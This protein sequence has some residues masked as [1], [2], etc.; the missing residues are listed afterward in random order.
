[1]E[2]FENIDIKKILE[3]AFSKKIL[4]I[5]AL[6]LILSN[7]IGYVYTYNY[8]IPEYKSSVTVLLVAD[9]N[10]ETQE[11]TQTDLNLNSGLISTYS[12]IVKSNNIVSK[13]IKNLNLN[14]S[15]KNLQNSI[16]AIQVNKTQFLEISVKN[17]NPTLAKEIANELAEVFTAEIK[18]IYNLQNINIVD[19]AEIQSKPCNINHTKDMIIF[20]AGGVCISVVLIMAIYFFDDTIKNEQDIELNVKL[21]NIG[22]LPIDK[23]NEALIIESNPKSHI[24]E[25]IKTLR[26][27]ILYTTNRKTI[28]ITSCRQS[29]GKSWV[30]RNLAVALAQANKTV[31]LVDTDFRKGSNINEIFN[32]QKQ[33]GLSDLITEV[34]DD[35][36]ENLEKTRKYI[37]ETQIP[38]L[39]IL[40]NGTIP[41][42]P[43]ELI[44]SKNME[45]LLKV[46]KN[47][48]DIVLLDSAQCLIFADSIALS[49]MVDNTILVAESKK[50]KI[51]D[52]KKAKK[53]IID[54]GGKISGVILNKSEL[55]KGKYYGQKYGY[56]YG[57]EEDEIG[58]IEEKRTEVTLDEII[59]YAKINMQNEIEIEDNLETI[60]EVESTENNIQISNEIKNVKSQLLSE[61]KNLKDHIFRFRKNDKYGER[62]DNI[63]E[64]INNL[65]E[66]QNI[67][68]N[69]ILEQ[70]NSKNYDE[71]F[72]Q[73]TEQI[74]NKN[75]NEK[76]E[77]IEDQIRNKNYN[78]QFA[79]IE[80]QINSK[81]YDE[82]F[83][84]INEQIDYKNYEKE[85]ELL[86]MQNNENMEIL[87]ETFMTQIEKM[88]AEI[89]NLKDMQINSNS[90]LLDKVKNIDYKQDLEKLNEKIDN[91]RYE[92]KLTEINQ[93]IE[94]NKQ[95]IKE[96]LDNKETNNIISFETLK[97]K[98]KQNKRV[99]TF[100]EGLSYEDLER[101]SPQ[102]IDLNNEAGFET[103]ISR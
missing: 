7:I 2:N 35:K 67:N 95:K 32:I 86:K 16:E 18:E 87:I 15:V 91:M 93:K 23:N 88:N 84:K 70:I 38:N 29:E 19:Y 3:I 90:E 12:S 94:E 48:Y 97:Q 5:V 82:Q 31:L 76:F 69:K 21:K 71:Q 37:K 59:E 41:P 81:N 80:E 100:D 45:K 47:M 51:N 50:T 6:I 61:I 75:Y 102:V 78:E 53:S 1:M 30:A 27:N 92:E 25:S 68:N 58:R 14:Y 99:F 11:L 66:I 34:V 13:V 10:K 20:M 55:Q 46:L 77:Q 56:Y 96:N 24:V 89:Q 33:E 54:V 62:F 26:T 72:A 79:K 28:L 8:K 64:E 43:S 22:T 73:I 52:L 17:P 57:K 63:V 4:I 42:N 60:E 65:K 98:R 40:Q 83:E 44:S 9:E 49:S 101:L 85:I 39:H 74:N 36:F 103:V